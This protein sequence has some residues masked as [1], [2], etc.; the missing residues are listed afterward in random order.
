MWIRKTAAWCDFSTNHFHS[1]YFFFSGSANFDSRE[2]EPPGSYINQ[3]GVVY[4]HS[5][6]FIRL[7]IRHPLPGEYW[8]WTNTHAIL[9]PLYSS[10]RREASRLTL[11]SIN[12]QYAYSFRW[13]GQC[14][15][16]RGWRLGRH[17]QICPWG[18]WTDSPDRL[19]EACRPPIPVPL[20]CGSGRRPV[21]RA[22]IATA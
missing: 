14:P 20:R 7:W 1:Q 21:P 8:N 18:D 19:E 9:L 12:I 10:K 3:G 22:C 15:G 13:H 11:I 5:N 17:V 6:N 4:A 16:I 2:A